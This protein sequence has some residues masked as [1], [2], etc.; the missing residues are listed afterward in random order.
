[1]SRRL[2]QHQCEVDMPRKRTELQNTNDAAAG[3]IR[4]RSLD[5]LDGR[6]ITAQKA[7]TMVESLE[8]DMGGADRLSTA[9]RALVVRAA[10]TT[11]IIENMEASALSGGDIDVAAYATL[12]NNLRRLLTTVGLQRR[13]RDVTPD[14]DEYV[15][16]KR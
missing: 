4:L 15:A 6:T 10:V 13:Q 11:A 7:R 2:I 5:D 1:M 9:E 14:L 16:G 3:K 8:A 12:T